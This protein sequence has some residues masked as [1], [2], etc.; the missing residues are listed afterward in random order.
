MVQNFKSETLNGNCVYHLRFSLVPSPTPIL[1]RL[2]CDLVGVVQ[3][4]HTNPERNFVYHLY[5]KPS[6]KSFFKPQFGQETMLNGHG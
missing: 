5:K 2:T 6:R 1:M 3:M 4:V